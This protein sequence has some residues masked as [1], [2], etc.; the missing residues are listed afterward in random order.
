[1]T[2][3]QLEAQAES[4]YSDMVI[5]FDIDLTARSAFRR[6]Y[7]VGFKAKPEENKARGYAVEEVEGV[8]AEQPNFYNTKLGKIAGHVIHETNGI[9]NALGAIPFNLE[10][11]IADNNIGDDGARL[12]QLKHAAVNA[13]KRLKE[14]ADYLYT[15]LKEYAAS[16]P[17]QIS[18]EE[19]EQMAL[20]YIKI[21]YPQAGHTMFCSLKIGYT[22]GFK[23]AL[24]LK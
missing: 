2:E 23:A 5:P 4:A 12:L 14:A 19:I 13:N 11:Y 20:D 10:K 18:E 8:T 7:V 24:N 3:E 17:K 22:E 6:G 15:Q 1:M 9:S 21:V 16:T